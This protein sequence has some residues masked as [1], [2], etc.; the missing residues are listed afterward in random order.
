MNGMTD[1]SATNSATESK[2]KAVCPICPHACSL[3]EG[4]LGICRARVARDGMVID[5]NYGR[6][7]SLAIDPIEKKPLARFMPGSQVLSIGSYGCNMRCAFCQ[8]ASIAQACSTDV[9]WREMAPQDI[10]EM[11]AMFAGQGNI[12]VAYTYNEPLVGFEFVRDTCVEVHDRGLKNVLVSNGQINPEPL[13]ELLP[14]I[15]AANIDLKGFTPEV[16]RELGGDLDTTLRTIEALAA[17]PTT[18]LEVTMLIVPG[19]NDS[20]EEVDAAAAWLASLDPQIPLH[21]SRFFGCYKMADADPTPVATVYSMV[22]VARAHLD[23][24]YPGNC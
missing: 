11:A 12:G 7:T 22:D 23:F 2:S 3:S 15:D 13:S 17:S 21:V 5:Q 20:A 4:Q 16:Y 19:L 6:I 10:A 14:L 8:N 24:V 18:H 9:E 1:I